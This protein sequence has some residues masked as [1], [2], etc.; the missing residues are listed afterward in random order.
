MVTGGNWY[1]GC[2]FLIHCSVVNES[3]FSILIYSYSKQIASK[4]ATCLAKRG[5]ILCDDLSSV[6]FR[7]KCFAANFPLFKFGCLFFES[8]SHEFSWFRY[9]CSMQLFLISRLRW[10]SDWLNYWDQF[11]I[12]FVK[13]VWITVSNLNH[14]SIP[15]NVWNQPTLTFH[16]T[17]FFENFKLFFLNPMC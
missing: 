8:Y 11:W 10:K 14:Y 12:L 7:M 17:T 2:E 6:C 16:I 15:I 1:V 5:L 3:E 4:L 13:F 9:I